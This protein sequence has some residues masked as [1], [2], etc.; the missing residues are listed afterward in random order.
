[1]NLKNIGTN[2]KKLRQEKN[3]TQA[4]LAEMV[5]ISTVH[6]S[7]I[8]TGRVCMSLECLLYICDALKTTPNNILLGEYNLSSYDVQSILQDNTSDLTSDENRFLVEIATL[9]EKL[10]INRA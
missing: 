1:M 9:M 8:E 5:D 3:L 10:K 2:I 7:H 6:I 4:Q